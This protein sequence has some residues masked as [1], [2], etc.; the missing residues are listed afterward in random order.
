M[1]GFKHV[2]FDAMTYV[3]HYKNGQLHRE[4]RGLSFFFF[5]PNSS[6]VAIPMGGNDL[7]FVFKE[8]TSDFQQLTIQ[9]QISYQINEPKQLADALDFTVNEK[10]QYKR[11][12]LEKLNQRTINEAQTAVS[13]LVNQMDLSKALKSAAELEQQLRKGLVDSPMVQLLGLKILG[14]NVLA[15]RAVPEMARALETET[16]EQLQQQADEAIY[17]RRNFA[18][19]QERRIKESEL[20]TE[21]AV[22][23]KQKQI[24][25]KKMELEVVQHENRRQLNEMKMEGNIELEKQRQTLV[26]QK[27]I[28]DRKLADTQAYVIDTTLAPYRELD[29]KLIT[30]LTNNPDPR[31]NLSLAF[32]ELAENASKIGNLN[33]SPDLLENLINRQS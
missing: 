22:Q 26:E 13:N 7:P 15:I 10:G 17:E 8:T 11:N 9:G 28:N 19:E 12:D 20:N 29:W 21:I 23:E 3:M 30:A 27:S 33:I 1:F 31:L 2:Q 18:V 25:E 24:V 4:G 32:R 6:I 5:R 14:V 16:R